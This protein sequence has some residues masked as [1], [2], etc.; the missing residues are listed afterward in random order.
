MIGSPFLHLSGVAVE[1]VS[2]TDMA[3]QTLLQHAVDYDR[4]DHVK[5]LLDKG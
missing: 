2:K 3:G 1:Q 4:Q 5:V